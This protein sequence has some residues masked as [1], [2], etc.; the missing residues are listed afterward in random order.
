VAG[1]CDLGN[2]L[3]KIMLILCLAER[4][5]DAQE[6]AEHVSTLCSQCSNL[7]KKTLNSSRII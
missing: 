7:N 4:L 1:F 2:E 5:S 3:H 6:I